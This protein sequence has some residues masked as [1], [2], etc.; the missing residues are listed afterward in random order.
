MR[1][2]QDE[3]EYKAN[4]PA[5]VEPSRAL[6]IPIPSVKVVYEKLIVEEG[7]PRGHFLTTVAIMGTV[8]LVILGATFPII[9]KLMGAAAIYGCVHAAVYYMF[10]QKRDYEDY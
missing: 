1:D 10:F 6:I 8:L 9:P 3:A 7:P 2:L 5:P 4:L